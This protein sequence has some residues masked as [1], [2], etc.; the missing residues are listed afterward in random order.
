MAKLPLDKPSLATCPIAHS[1]SVFGDSWCL[2]I[3]R[4]AHSGLTRFDDFRTS[5]G[6]APSM[7]TKRLA[8]LVQE[9]LLEKR[10]YSEHPPREEYLLTAAGQDVLP[11]LFSIGAWGRT[12]KLCDTPAQMPIFTDSETGLEIKPVVIDKNTGIEIGKRAISRQR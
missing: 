9:G 12:H 5:L 6:I 8:T 4:D 3:L 10:S 11:V 2:L 1:L 7:L